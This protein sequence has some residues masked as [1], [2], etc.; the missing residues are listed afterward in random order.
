MRSARSPLCDD[1]SV[2]ETPDF[3]RIELAQCES[4][5]VSEPI[6]LREAERT[7]PLLA[8]LGHPARLRLM[9][10][11][12]AH[13][14]REACVCDLEGVFDLDQDAILEHLRTLVEAGLVE[15][16]QHGVWGFYRVRS[17][18]LSDLVS[19]TGGMTR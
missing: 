11:I 13:A 9:S 19:V 3:P 18:V 1:E 5:L 4:S 6:S 8:A 10:M 17:G 12:A 7:A 2:S 16:V 14:S 15:R